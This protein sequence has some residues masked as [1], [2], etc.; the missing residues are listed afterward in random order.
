M[1]VIAIFIGNHILPKLKKADFVAVE[2]KSPSNLTENAT[3]KAYDSAE[4]MIAIQFESSITNNVVRFIKNDRD[5]I[6]SHENIYSQIATLL[7]QTLEVDNQ[8]TN[9]LLF[10]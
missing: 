4:D 5:I 2:P 8:E 1:K 6:A 9:N 10:E 3:N 7:Y